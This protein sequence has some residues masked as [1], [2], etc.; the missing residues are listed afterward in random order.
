MSNLDDLLAPWRQVVRQEAEG[1]AIT[2]ATETPWRVRVQMGHRMRLGT[3]IT[4]RVLVDGKALEQYASE[5]LLGGE[6][7]HAAS[8]TSY[9]QEIPKG[10]VVESVIEIFE[11]DIPPQHLWS[12]T[13]GRYRTLWTH[14]YTTPVR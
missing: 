4:T 7:W 11:T 6:P 8:S 5:E 1:W 12:P 10:A 13:G 3:R 2:W 14:T 9:Y